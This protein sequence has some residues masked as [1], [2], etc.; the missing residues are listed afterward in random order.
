MR[1]M[2][3]FAAALLLFALPTAAPAATKPEAGPIPGDATWALVA[4][5]AAQGAAAGKAL[6]AAADTRGLQRGFANGLQSGLG[7]HPFDADALSAAGVDLQQPIA[8]GSS[9]GV[10]LAAVYLA[11]G[12]TS[13][14]LERWLDG[15]GKAEAAGTHRGWSV[16]VARKGD[17]IEAAYALGGRRAITARLVEPRGDVRAVLHR[18]IEGALGARSSLAAQ[19]QFDAARKAVTAPWYVWRRGR[20]VTVATAL[21][22]EAPDELRMQGHAHVRAQE[23]LLGSGSAYPAA[24][25]QGDLLLARMVLSRESRTAQGAVSQGVRFLLEQ[26]CGTCDDA[27]RAREASRIAASLA[28]PAALAVSQL[29]ASAI[30][31]DRIGP[32]ATPFAWVAQVRDPAAAARTLDNAAKALGAAGERDRSVPSAIGT[33]HFGLRGDR[34]YVASDAALRDRLLA[35]T[36]GAASGKGAPFELTV[37]PRRIGQALAGLSV[38]DAL[39]GG[40]VAQLF[41]LRVQLGPLLGESGPLQLQAA[42]Q[43]K[44]AYRID[45]RWDLRGPQTP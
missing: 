26:A 37:E 44:G 13:A 3:A 4:P 7:F 45:A 29:D 35:A 33:L 23:P 30:Q 36:E 12:A 41:A 28:G 20:D 21:T 40:L 11:D 27:T 9:G 16:H 39:R 42:P 25:A 2:L 17:R 1:S 8:F 19:A 22:L 15:V 5:T 43:G 6:A 32:G 31:G 18:A 38:R 14:H 34:L 10:E 24:R